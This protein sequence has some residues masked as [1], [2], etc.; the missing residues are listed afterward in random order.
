MGYKSAEHRDA[1][2]A[3]VQAAYS[4]WPNFGDLPVTQEIGDVIYKDIQG[5]VDEKAGP[6]NDQYVECLYAL[7]FKGGTIVGRR[8][9]TPTV[10]AS[11]PP[12]PK[13]KI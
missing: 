8:E 10:V 5:P 1:V 2:V 3:A 4:K 11:V 13:P 9:A 12:K 7:A 6:T